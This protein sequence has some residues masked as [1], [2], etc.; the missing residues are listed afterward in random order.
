VVRKNIDVLYFYGPQKED[1]AEVLFNYYV[2]TCMVFDGI[3]KKNR[4]AWKYGAGLL[5]IFIGLNMIILSNFF[6]W[7]SGLWNLIMIKLLSH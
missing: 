6:W 4:V 1:Y 5:Q 3:E 7:Y 2:F